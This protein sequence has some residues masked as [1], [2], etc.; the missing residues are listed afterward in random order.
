MAAKRRHRRFYSA[1]PLPR[2]GQALELN[3]EQTRHLKTIIRLKEGDECLVADSEGREASAAIKRF[4]SR[5]TTELMILSEP[6]QASETMIPISIYQAMPRLGKLEFLIQKGQELGLAHLWPLETQRTVIK[7]DPKRETSKLDRWGKIV[8]EAAKQSGA[9]RILE[10]H[11]PVSIQEAADSL[12]PDSLVAVFHPAAEA[13]AFRDWLNDLQADRQTSSLHL[14]FGP[15]G[16]FSLKE[17]EFLQSAAK[18]RKWRMNLVHLG[19]AILRADTAFIGVLAAL[20][21]LLEPKK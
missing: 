10:I 21:L 4:T 17:I 1:S 8:R 14:F 11:G 13:Q 6:V 3:A 12:K 18:E 5:N 9:S 15:E 7:I 20:R 16:G 2:A 19:K